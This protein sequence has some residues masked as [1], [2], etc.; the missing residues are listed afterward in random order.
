VQESICTGPSS[1][2][3]FSL[4]NIPGQRFS[5]QGARVKLRAGIV[6]ALQSF[7]AVGAGDY[8]PELFP[9]QFHKLWAACTK[10]AENNSFILILPI[11]QSE[12]LLNILHLSNGYTA[13]LWAPLF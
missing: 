6:P 1:I 11:T 5:T 10:L 12:R 13:P 7:Y 9:S 8:L 4:V 3:C 2:N